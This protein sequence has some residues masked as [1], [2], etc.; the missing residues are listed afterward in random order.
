MSFNVIFENRSLEN[1]SEFTLF[2]SNAHILRFTMEMH[3][4]HFQWLYDS[5][6]ELSNLFEK[7][8]F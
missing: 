7:V 6:T 5:K 2:F 3:K 8:Y 4:M 1:N